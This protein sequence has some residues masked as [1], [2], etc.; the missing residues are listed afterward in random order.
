MQNQKKTFVRVFRCWAEPKRC[1]KCSTSLSP[2]GHGSTTLCGGC[3][4]ENRAQRKKLKKPPLDPVVD[5]SCQQKEAEYQTWLAQRVT[6]TESRLDEL[7]LTLIRSLRAACLREPLDFNQVRDVAAR[8][9]TSGHGYFV[10]LIPKELTRLRKPSPATLP[11]SNNPRST[12]GRST[13]P[14]SFPMRVAWT[15]P[16]PQPFSRKGNSTG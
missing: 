15:Q 4:I 1:K 2:Q 12:V 5:P 6:D 3:A 7:T 11:T 16:R 8:A 13:P 10:G 14:I 9:R